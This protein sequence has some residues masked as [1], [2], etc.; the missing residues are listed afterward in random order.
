MSLREELIEIL[1]GS[2][3]KYCQTQDARVLQIDHVFGNGKEM[4]LS[5]KDV[6]QIYLDNPYM[7]NQELQ[8]LCC[9]CHRIKSITSG[10]LG[11]R[12][13]EPKPIIVKESDIPR[14]ILDNIEWYE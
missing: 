5:K 14:N 6:I 13:G 12:R 3:C 10:D 2:K 11:R 1:G 4:P 9:N 8:I 7:A